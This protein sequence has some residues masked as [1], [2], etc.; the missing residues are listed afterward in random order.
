YPLHRE[1]PAGRLERDEPEEVRALLAVRRTEPAARGH[2]GAP[3]RQGF[4]VL[5]ELR[6]V[7]GQAGAGE[8]LPHLDPGHRGPALG[9]PAGLL[10]A[11][12]P[13]GGRRTVEHGRQPVRQVRVVP[14]EAMPETYS[15]S[16]TGAMNATLRTIVRQGARTLRALV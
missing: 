15:S 4:R 10:P 3:G 1:Q 16:N 8:L 2:A 12:Q 5:P 13:V 7:L 6:H 14:K 11:E 9:G